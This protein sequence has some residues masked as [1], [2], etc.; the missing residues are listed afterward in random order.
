MMHFYGAEARDY[1]ENYNGPEQSKPWTNLF[2]AI[3]VEPIDWVCKN[4]EPILYIF[5]GHFYF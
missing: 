2:V 5:D 3:K 1:E 4:I